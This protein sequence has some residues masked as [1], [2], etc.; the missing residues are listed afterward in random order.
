V[1]ASTGTDFTIS[2][3]GSTHT[4]SIPDAGPAAR[5]LVTTGAQTFAGT[6]TFSSAPVFSTLT[7]GSV[8]FA[9]PGGLLSQSNATLFWNDS[10]GRLGVGTN[11]PNNRGEISHGTAGN[12]G[13]R[14]TNLTSAG[15]LGTNANGDVIEGAAAKYGD[16]KTGIQ[17]ADHDGWIRLDG[18]AKSSLT[19]SQQAQATSLGIGANLPNA[20]DS[21]LSQ[22]G[23]ALGS[24]T[25]SNTKTIAQNQLPNVTL[26]GSTSSNSAG[27]PSGTI[28]SGGAHTHS[29]SDAGAS[30]EETAL[31]W[32]DHPASTSSSGRTTGSAG[33]HSHS[34]SGSPLGNHSH[35]ITTSSINGGVAQQS[36][37][38]QSQTMSV[39]V[40]MYL[41]T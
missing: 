25:G 34:F 20:T 2:S 12:S 37:N 32:G 29:Y 17:P 21:V 38:V 19:A 30:S 31:G 6:K 41:G 27:T 14:L 9:G 40:F 8:F 28:G 4:F 5:G 26:G 24:V 16:V 22:N 36:L 15:T 35:T 18:R 10:T 39:N 1:T 13:L 33:N 11:S 23:A 3:T 7:Q